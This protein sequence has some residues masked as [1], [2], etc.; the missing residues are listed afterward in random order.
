MAYIL[1]YIW[2]DG[3]LNLRGGSG[4]S[5][6]FNCR[7]QDEEILFNIREELGLSV[8]VSRATSSKLVVSGAPLR[9]VFLDF[10]GIP[11]GRT[12]CD[13]LFPVVTDEFLGHFL[14]GY[15]DGD[16]CVSP[17]SGFGM[18]IS[19]LGGWSFTIGLR[20]RLISFLT[21]SRREV[22]KMD[23]CFK[24]TW[25]ARDD[26]KKIAGLMYPSGNYMPSL[27]RKKKRLM[28]FVQEPSS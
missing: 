2:A 8:S 25:G 19:F 4:F 28:P 22:E 27:S 20:D 11:P 15:F 12:F 17:S 21:V 14:R 3:Y 7:T 24:V 6:E 9:E 26:V 23:G 1:G 10:H 5:V 13:P 16:G 18:R